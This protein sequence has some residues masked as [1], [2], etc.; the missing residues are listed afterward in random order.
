M[1]QRRQRLTTIVGSGALSVWERVESREIRRENRHGNLGT[2]SGDG[3]GD[4]PL[5]LRASVGVDSKT[6]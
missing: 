1:I 2:R 3:D 5:L 4:N 6:R